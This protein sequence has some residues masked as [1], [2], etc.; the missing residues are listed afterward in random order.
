MDSATIRE[1][2]ATAQGLFGE[3]KFRE[4][5]E[6]LDELNQV[7]PNQKDLLYSRALCLHKLGKTSEAALICDHLSQV[8]SDPRGSALKEEMGRDLFPAWDDAQP[9]SQ[10]PAVAA[11]EPSRKRKRLRRLS[12]SVTGALAAVFFTSRKRVEA[13]LEGSGPKGEIGDASSAAE[14]GARRV[15]DSDALPTSSSS[16]QSLSTGRRGDSLGTDGAGN[17]GSR[18]LDVSSSRGGGPAGPDTTGATSG[19]VSM[20]RRL[21]RASGLA[22]AFAALRRSRR[23]PLRL[24]GGILLIA[25]LCTLAMYLAAGRRFSPQATPPPPP[26]P[27]AAHFPEHPLFAHLS[28]RDWNSPAETPW[29]P[30]STPLGYASGNV[31]IPAAKE[32]RLHGVNASNLTDEIL[33]QLASMPGLHTVD[34]SAGYVDENVLGFL[35]KLPGVKALDLSHATVTPTALLALQGHPGLESVDLKAVGVQP[36]LMEVLKTLPRLKQLDLSREWNCNDHDQIYDEH[37]NHLASMTTLTSLSLANCKKITDEGLKQIGKLTSL[38]KLDLRGCQ[39]ITDEGLSALSALNHLRELDLSGVLTVTAKGI[40]NLGRLMSLES[41]NLSGCQGIRDEALAALKALSGLKRLNLREISEITDAGLAELPALPNLVSLEL[42]HNWKVTDEGMRH[43]GQIKT[44]KDFFL[45]QVGTVSDAGIAHLTGINALES[46]WMGWNKAV[47]SQSLA[48]VAQLASLRK[49]EIGGWDKLN[50]A[51]FAH[52]AALPNLESLMLPRV[53]ISAG[54]DGSRLGRLRDFH[55]IKRLGMSFE[56]VTSEDLEALASLTTL[57]E[58]T[59]WFMSGGVEISSLPK[60]SALKELSLIG[61]DLDEKQF[62]C[63]ER[64]TSLRKLRLEFVCIEPEG[65]RHFAAARPDCELVQKRVWDGRSLHFP[66]DRSLGMVDRG[67][68]RAVQARGTVMVDLTPR[69]LVLD[70]E[71]ASDLSPLESLPPDA[72]GELDMGSAEVP[73][74]QLAYVGK[75]SELR[76]FSLVDGKV[77]GDG[78]LDGL[79]GLSKLRQ[80]NLSGTDL[81]P[82]GLRGIGGMAELTVLSLNRAK[83]SKEGV[84]ELSQLAKVCELDLSE[85]DI[86]GEVLEAIA[87]M[88][89]LLK[90]KLSDTSITDDDLVHLKGLSALRELDLHGTAITGSGLVHLQGLALDCLSLERL[91]QLD[92]KNLAF[93]AAMKGLDALT[94]RGSNLTDEA[95]VYVGKLR[96][97]SKWLNLSENPITDAGLVH[98]A[99]LDL[100]RIYLSKTGVKGPGLVNLRNMGHLDIISLMG[101]PISDE[102]VNYLGALVP[103]RKLYIGKSRNT[104][105][106]LKLSTSHG[107]YCLDHTDGPLSVEAIE[108]LKIWF[109]MGVP[110]YPMEPLQIE[111]ETEKTPP[112]ADAPKPAEP[113]EGTVSAPQAD[114]TPDAD[115]PAPVDAP[116]PAEPTEV[117]SAAPR[118]EKVPPTGADK[119]SDGRTLHF[120]S[121]VIVGSLF[122]RDLG[123]TDIKAWTRLGNALGDVKVPT[124]KEVRLMVDT[125][126]LFFLRALAPDDIQALNLS[127]TKASDA[128]V[129]P[130]MSWTSLQTLDLR[131]TEVSEAKAQEIGQRMPNCRVLR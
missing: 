121:S 22:A 130:V 8:L 58:L 86:D 12:E 114:K 21:Y 47:T 1:K 106:A 32:V 84:A 116:K 85:T 27:F 122:V 74:E 19:R 98:L 75:L 2:Y 111:P 45:H 4:A 63:L 88:K 128:E 83:V 120:P 7:F 43:V 10:P 125:S 38:E 9:P 105:T 92:Q 127:R 3:G 124:G 46:L 78:G 76:K 5:L 44:L 107:D 41:L 34:L 53:K 81:G 103:P 15:G 11:P 25:L 49:L 50:G 129:E 40:A 66:E 82:G 31:N 60:L 119:S 110:I 57:E 70:R 112:D 90:L 104:E 6:I 100:R 131:G 113:V 33:N 64:L 89:K 79:R 29:N 28:I 48:S 77:V 30:I 13:S 73:S 109:M 55:H 36:E 96:S 51:A 24:V 14:S 101:S 62:A 91:G 69:R 117:A 52:L 126:D 61:T 26:G 37:L 67:Y 87:G 65:I 59:V 99:P 23:K 94:L 42:S 102:T 118:T 18:P 71:A 56:D 72:L 108:K 115:A 80:L 97:L 17:A 54:E 93:L 95:L 16:E 39:G 35:K 20:G 123:S 68:G